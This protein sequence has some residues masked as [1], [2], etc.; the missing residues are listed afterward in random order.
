MTIDVLGIGCPNCK[1]LERNVRQAASDLGLDVTIRKVED[2]PSILGY[3]VQTMPA[4]VLD[5]EVIVS[6]RVPSPRQL[7]DLLRPDAATTPPSM[8]R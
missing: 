6:G 5:G 2:L 8:S 7:A 4:L 3:G 1:R